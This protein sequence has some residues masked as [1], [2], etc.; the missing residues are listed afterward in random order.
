MSE[1]EQP[2]S[3]NPAAPIQPIV[4]P[5]A[6]Q[7]SLAPEVVGVLNSGLATLAKVDETKHKIASLKT[8]STEKVLEA[9]LADT[10]DEREHES[11]R[12]LRLLVFAGA[13]IVLAFAFGIYGGSDVQIDRQI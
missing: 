12:H 1:N 8:R 4:Q 9:N 7:L 13:I 3:G 6:T 2:A 5:N 11:R 10:K